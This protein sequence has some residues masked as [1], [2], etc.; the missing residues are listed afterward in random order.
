MCNF[1]THNRSYIYMVYY[2]TP[3]IVAINDMV[4]LLLIFAS[5]VLIFSIKI[6]KP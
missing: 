5:F 1:N 6:P 2:L 4:D 3:N